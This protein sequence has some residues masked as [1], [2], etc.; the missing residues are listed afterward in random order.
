MELVGVR[1]EDA[2]IMGK[3][4]EDDLLWQPLRVKVWTGTLS[5]K[6]MVP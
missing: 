5:M 4:E 3:V 1:E 2:E 6:K